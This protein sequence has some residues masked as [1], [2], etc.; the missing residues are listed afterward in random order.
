M[1][2]SVLEGQDA[3]DYINSVHLVDSDRST[4]LAVSAVD[5]DRFRYFFYGGEQHP[6]TGACLCPKYYHPWQY[7]PYGLLVEHV[8]WSGEVDFAKPGTYQL[9]YTARE[10]PASE[11]TLISHPECKVSMETSG[12]FSRTVDVVVELGDV[13]NPDG[14]SIGRVVSTGLVRPPDAVGWDIRVCGDPIGSAEGCFLRER[15]EQVDNDCS[16]EDPELNIQ[17]GWVLIGNNPDPRGDCFGDDVG[18]G[19]WG[20]DCA[21]LPCTRKVKQSFDLACPMGVVPPPLS[22]FREV[23]SHYHQFS[24]GCASPP[25]LGQLE[26]SLSW[27]MDSEGNG[28]VS[29][30]NGGSLIFPYEGCFSHCHGSTP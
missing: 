25:N 23:H 30:G 17:E 21:Y 14:F 3:V 15:V 29:P 24:V 7:V 6:V 20:V 19:I 10:I 5:M 8:G 9:T 27:G 12:Q 22:R 28:G 4:G 13:C 16:E 1:N 18:I 2:P 11:I 26:L